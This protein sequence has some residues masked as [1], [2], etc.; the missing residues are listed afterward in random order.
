MDF[1]ISDALLSP[2]ERYIR[3]VV[4]AGRLPKGTKPEDLTSKDKE[5]IAADKKGTLK[6]GLT[7]KKI[8]ELCKRLATIKTAYLP[9]IY[10][11][12]DLEELR[13]KFK[14]QGTSLEPAQE[15]FKTR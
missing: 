12:T 4:E 11:I 10:L 2:E 6:D 15:F 9:Q 8:Q 7:D 1:L 14:S 5:I 13:E 3:D